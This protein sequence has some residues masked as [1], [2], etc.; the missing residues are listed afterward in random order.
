MFERQTKWNL[1]PEED[2]EEWVLGRDDYP[3]AG[4]RKEHFRAHLEAEVAEGLMEKMT[5]EEFVETFGSH[6]AIASLARLVEDA[7]TGMKRVVRDGAHGIGVNNR[8]RCLDKVRMPSGREKRALLEE[9][10][11]EAQV[12]ISLVGASRR[13]TGGFY[14]RW[15]RE[16]SLGAVLT[17]KMVMCTSTRRGDIHPVLV[18][19]D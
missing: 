8:I 3:S 1:D 18:G 2:L 17:P 16:D 9:Y 7:E 11:K 12:V 15:R 13:P 19:A 10:K 5:E 6:R 14:M 4:E